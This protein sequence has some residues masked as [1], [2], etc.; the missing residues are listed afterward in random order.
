MRVLYRYSLEIAGALISFF[1]FIVMIGNQSDPT[2]SAGPLA[3]GLIDLEW[4][5]RPVSVL[6]L[7][8]CV[9]YALL[10]QLPLSILVKSYFPSIAKRFA[11]G[12]TVEVSKR[13]ERFVI[14]LV[15]LSILLL[16]LY[17]YFRYNELIG[18]DSGGYLYGLFVIQ[19]HPELAFAG[20]SIGPSLSFVLTFAPLDLFGFLGMP[21]ETVLVAE[22]IFLS[23]FY[24]L[25]NY[26]LAGTKVDKFTV[27]LTVVISAFSLNAEFSTSI[28]FRNAMGLSLM[29]LAFACYLRYLRHGQRKYAIFVSLL[30][31]IML[32]QYPFIVLTFIGITALF[33]LTQLLPFGLKGSFLQKSKRLL[34]PILVPVVLLGVTGV[35]FATNQL[36]RGLPFDLSTLASNT[37]AGFGA[38]VEVSHLLPTFWV[39]LF[40][41]PFYSFFADN[42]LILFLACVG[43]FGILTIPNQ[44]EADISFRNLIFSWCAFVT[45]SIFLGGTEGYREVLNYPL[46]IISAMGTMWVIRLILRKPSGRP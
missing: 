22:A 7:V 12:W 36:T 3:R 6:V 28:L 35:L 14:L 33:I 2:G 13:Q 5:F 23:L 19:E 16:R 8:Y 32:I 29:T 15:T 31:L 40:D 46:P 34:M 1:L 30:T 37:F 11:T 42:L 18:L 39:S 44:T 9:V 4:A 17:P 25:C 20:A 41:E 26:V 27:L 21:W 38:G 10:W 45:I 43:L 24:I